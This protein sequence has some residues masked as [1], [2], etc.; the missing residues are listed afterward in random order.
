MINVQSLSEITLENVVKE[1]SFDFFLGYL[2]HETRSIYVL[3]RSHEVCARR[4][5]LVE[6]NLHHLKQERIHP[7]WAKKTEQI[8][9]LVQDDKP[10]DDLL[11]QAIAEKLYAFGEE[12]SP[13]SILLDV[14]SMP[15][16]IIAS[17]M[18]TIEDVAATRKIEMFVAY[19]LAKYTPPS[20]HNLVN[21]T[22]GPVHPSFTGFSIDSGLPVA[23][24]VG[25]GYEK[26]KALGAVEYVQSSDWWVFVPT[27][28]ESRYLKKV[29]QH[30]QTILRVVGSD[31]R[32]EYSVHSPLLTLSRLES[33]VSSL[34]STHKT[35][36]LPFGPKIFFFCSLLVSLVHKNCAVWH[37]SGE[38]PATRAD[39]SPSAYVMCLSFCLNADSVEDQYNAI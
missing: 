17:V 37:V 29:E 38:R 33:L 14:S 16:S 4:I 5:M 32:F 36:L 1:R 19:C 35:V 31:R 10:A 21:K 15:R 3:K 27:S 20:E 12:N 6:E 23:A 18:A 39:I 8:R 9:V 28:E 2:C 25:L 13:I 24:V 7:A 22:V 26:G 11:E 30:N 34:R